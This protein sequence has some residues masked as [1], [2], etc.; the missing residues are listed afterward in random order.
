LFD[1]GLSPSEALRQYCQGHGKAQIKVARELIDILPAAAIIEVL[2]YLVEDYWNRRSGWPDL[3]VYRDNEFFFAE[4]KS[5]GDKLG[6]NQMRWIRDNEERLHF[7]F[8]LVQIHKQATRPGYVSSRA[9]TANRI[10]C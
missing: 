2:W 3:L 9:A 8:K 5:S 4:V 7:P 1:L 6:V 10:S